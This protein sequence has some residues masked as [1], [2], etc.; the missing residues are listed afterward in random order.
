MITIDGSQGEGGGQILR[1]SLALALLTGKSFQLNNIRARRSKPGLQPQHLMSVRAAATVGQA[2]VQGAALHSSDLVFEPGTVQAGKYHFAIGTAGA[3][4]LV[5]HTIYLPLA[6]RGGAPSEILLEGGT[7][8]TAS[9]CFHFLHVTWA[10]YLELLGLHLKLS[11][12]RPGF[13][14]RGGGCVEVHVQPCSQLQRLDLRERS[15]IN[16]ISGFSAVAGLPEN[17]GTR[18]ARRAI[19]RLQSLGK[20]VRISQETWAGGPGTVLALVLETA[21]VPTMFFGLGARGKPAERVADEAAD[22]ALAYLKEDP[23]AVDSHSADQL[24]LPLALANGPSEFTVSKV[25]NH[26]L[27]NIAV[28]QLF[29]ERD[30]IC[31]GEEGERGSVRIP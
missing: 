4:G 23:A 6:L 14:P 17:I 5:L 26:L 11:M 10:G 20:K 8:V 12:R 18:Q 27:T 21:P 9:P 3:V 29:I 16:K 24:V 7:H 1:T 2:E 13:Y 31:L 19:N 22:Q 15:R 25:T 30:I 28:I